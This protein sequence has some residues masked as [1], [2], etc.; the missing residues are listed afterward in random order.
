MKK[1]AMEFKAKVEKSGAW[2]APIVTEIAEAKKFWMAEEYHQHYLVKNPGGYDNHYL[3]NISFD[4][5]AKKK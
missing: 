5:S 1:E 4:D 3:R 2:K